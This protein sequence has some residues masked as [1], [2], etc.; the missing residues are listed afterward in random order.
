L[1]QFRF[2]AD[3]VDLLPAKTIAFLQ[4]RLQF[5]LYSQRYVKGDGVDELHQQVGY[6]PIDLSP[7][8]A[9]ADRLGIFDSF[10]LTDIVWC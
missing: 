5:L 1:G 10:S 4:L 7:R 9:L 2:I 6:K 8:D 3:P